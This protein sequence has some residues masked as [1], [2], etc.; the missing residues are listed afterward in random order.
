[1]P[2]PRPPK[3]RREIRIGAVVSGTRAATSGG[4]GNA[5]T[6]RPLS[7]REI[8]APVAV[9]R[10]APELPVMEAPAATRAIEVAPGSCGARGV[11]GAVRTSAADSGADRSRRLRFIGAAAGRVGGDGVVCGRGWS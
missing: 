4:G 5:T 10:L 9:L 1:M 11:G 8:W 6:A 7:S 3:P 2:P